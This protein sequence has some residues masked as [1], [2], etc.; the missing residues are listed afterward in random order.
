MQPDDLLGAA[1]FAASLVAFF[2]IATACGA[3]A[4]A[5]FLG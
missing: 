4:A 1:A 5:C 3:Y 2:A